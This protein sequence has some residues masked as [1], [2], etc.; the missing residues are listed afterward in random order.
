MAR[1]SRTPYAEL[2]VMRCADPRQWSVSLVR[3][4]VEEAMN[5]LACASHCHRYILI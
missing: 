3:I 1:A 5:A 2:P 4:P